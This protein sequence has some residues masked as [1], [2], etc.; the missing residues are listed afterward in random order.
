MT[1]KRRNG[2]KIF[3]GLQLR[4][5]LASQRTRSARNPS[6]QA[7]PES[8]RSMVKSGKLGIF[9]LISRETC[10]KSVSRD[11]PMSCSSLEPI[12]P[13]KVP[14]RNMNS[15]QPGMLFSVHSDMADSNY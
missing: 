8:A 6:R 3:S 11:A 12:T 4:A 15:S 10:D 9:K 14:N 7:D 5:T 1:S 13:Q 2:M